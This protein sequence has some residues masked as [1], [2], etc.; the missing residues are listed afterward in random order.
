MEIFLP[1]NSSGAMYATYIFNYILHFR[2]WR[3][4]LSC[5]WFYRPRI[6]I[7]DIDR[8]ANRPFKEEIKY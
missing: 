4:A 8:I 6:W 5:F 7:M 3:L 1:G 2:I